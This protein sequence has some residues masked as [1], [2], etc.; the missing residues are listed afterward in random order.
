LGQQAEGN[1]DQ[2]GKLFEWVG[3]C[4]MAPSQFLHQTFTIA[5]YRNRYWPAGSFF[6]DKIMNLSVASVSKTGLRLSAL[7]LAMLPLALATP[8]AAQ[9]TNQDMSVSSG[10]ASDAPKKD[11]EITI[12]AG[13]GV[14]PDYYGSK[15]TEFDFVPVIDIVYKNRFFFG[16]EGLGIYAV[17]SEESGLTLGAAI[18]PS[19]S[20]QKRFLE[21][22][23]RGLGTIKTSV[24]GRVFASYAP[25]APVSLSVSFAKDFGGTKG[26][27]ADVGLE[28]G[29]PLG[30]KLLVGANVGLSYWDRKLT[31]GFFGVTQAQSVRTGF[32]T[33]KAKLGFNSYSFG[34][35]SIYKLTDHFNLNLIL[36]GER[37]LEDSARSPVIERKLDRSAIFAVSYTF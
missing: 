18:A 7:T 35:T 23:L 15:K 11:L 37:R 19:N 10:Q 8:L 28:A 1:D 25:I 17:N 12:G 27:Q 6:L 26:Y 31:Q 32:R 36:A 24:Q 5:N 13:V 2:Y 16:T 34:L 20:R 4:S 30:E 33:F 9:N 3:L 22:R 14:A 29:V 21:P